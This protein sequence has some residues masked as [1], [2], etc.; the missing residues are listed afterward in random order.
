[1]KKKVLNFSVFFSIFA[2]FV[3]SGCGGSSSKYSDPIDYNDAIIDE[4]NKVG[5]YVSMLDSLAG[6][7]D[8]DYENYE[9]VRKE[10]LKQIELAKKEVEKIGDYKG[11]S[12]LKDATL[13]LLDEA[14][15]LLEYNWKEIGEKMRDADKLS[16]DELYDLVDFIDNTYNKQDEITAEFDEV[17]QKFADKHGYQIAY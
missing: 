15:E 2:L 4:V 6:E 9:K 11:D 10:G 16:D 7:D 3:F 8:F 14:K 17:H 12:D 5:D 13:T 1:M